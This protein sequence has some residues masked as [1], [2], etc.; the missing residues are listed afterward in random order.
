MVIK[1]QFSSIL[2]VN[3]NGSMKRHVCLTV[4]CVEGEKFNA[5]PDLDKGRR[6]M[7][8]ARRERRLVLTASSHVYSAKHPER[9]PRSQGPGRMQN[10]IKLK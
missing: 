4:R 1:L 2:E 8:G 9:R 7:M 6:H 3:M 5:V 10:C